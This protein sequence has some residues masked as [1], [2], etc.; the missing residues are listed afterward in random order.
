MDGWEETEMLVMRAVKHT[1]GGPSNTQ[2]DTT[3]QAPFADALKRSSKADINAVRT[4]PGRSKELVS[5]NRWTDL[6]FG[7]TGWSPES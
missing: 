4:N 1:P 2:K 3:L 6:P 7:F 5:P